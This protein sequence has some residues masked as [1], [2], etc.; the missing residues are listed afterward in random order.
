LLTPDIAVGADGSWV[1]RERRGFPQ[2]SGFGA[3]SLTVKGRVFE[4][5]PHEAL[6]SAAFTW[7]IG[8]SGDRSVGGGGPNALQPA[9]L[10]GKGFGDLPDSVEWLRPFAITGA[11]AAEFPTSR[12]TSTIGVDAMTGQLARMPTRAGSTLHW[13]LALEYSTFYLTDRFTGGP[14]TEEP[15]NQLVPLVEFAFDT[16]IGG[17]DSHQT[18]GTMNPGLTYVA[19]S[20]QVGAEAIVPL[21]REAGRSVGA[22]VQLTLFLTDLLPALFEHPVF[23]R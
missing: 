6:V 5:D 23:G 19:E 11:V 1:Q 3:T 14:P 21:N 17:G 13:G 12:S 7:S 4:N 22:R 16:P 8:G 20:W 2:Q 15:L 10:F 18:A 9:V